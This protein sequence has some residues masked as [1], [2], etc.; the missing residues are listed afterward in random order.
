MIKFEKDVLFVDKNN[1][2]IKFEDK[3]RLNVVMFLQDNKIFLVF[4]N[5]IVEV[6]LIEETDKYFKFKEVFE[7]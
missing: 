5:S 6:E 4:N 3:N 1:N 7:Q 2:E